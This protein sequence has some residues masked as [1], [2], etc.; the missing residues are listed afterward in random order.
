MTSR[1]H[2][3]QGSQWRQQVVPQFHRYRLVARCQRGEA[4]VG[5]SY[6]GCTA[7]VGRLWGDC[8][9]VATSQAPLW[10]PF[11]LAPAACLKLGAAI[12]FNQIAVAWV[13]WRPR[14]AT[15]VLGQSACKPGVLGQ[16]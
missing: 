9:D 13:C 3:P 14:F 16:G 5:G 4:F 2:H 10:W 15:D 6:G 7:L 8:A 11:Q 12:A 1:T